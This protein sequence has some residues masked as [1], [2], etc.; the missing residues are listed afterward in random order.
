MNLWDLPI[1]RLVHEWNRIDEGFT[2]HAAIRWLC[3]NDR[4]YLLVRACRRDDALHPWLLARCREV[5]RNPDGYLDLWAREHYKST[6]ITFAGSIQEILK[7]PEITIAIFSHTRPIARKFWTQIKQEFESNIVLKTIFPDV[8]YQDPQKEAPRW[9]E[10]KGIVVKRKQNIRESTLES[11]GLVD[12]QPTGAH[13]KLM[14]YDDVMTQES[15]STPE[16][17]AKTTAAWELSDNLGM[18]GGRKW[19]IGTRYSFADTYGA[20][21]TRGSVAARVY[22]ATKDGE[23]D[24]E[25]VFFTPEVWEQKKRDQGEQVIACQMLQNPIAGQQAMF[26]AEWLQ[27]Y[28]V[29]PETVNVYIMCDPARSMKKDSAKTA[30]AVVAVDA[31]RNK[32]LVDGMNHRM[33]L[34]ERWESLRSLWRKWNDMPGVQTVAVGYE[35]Y[36]AQADLEY[37]QE[38]MDVEGFAFPI[39]EL[40]WPR[41]G[42]GSKEDRVQRLVPDFRNSRFYLPYDT[43]EKRYTSQQKRAILEGSPYRVARP[44]RRKDN[45]GNLYD[46]RRQ[47]VEQVHFFPFGSQKDLI[48]AVSRIYDMD[49]QAPVTL[50]EFDLEPEVTVD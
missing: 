35:R 15:V 37:F 23:P 6:I 32:Y 10:E 34:K 7:D 36:G 16:Q 21:L 14:I 28:E 42:L 2:N 33:D 24:G 9:S 26:R 46:L 38:R 1:D 30:M 47:F 41:E 19:H 11:W 45:D 18:A 17:I 3:L 22:P 12:G 43:D 50:G 5:E 13:F 20:I 49:V 27:T 44:I 40:E 4:Y 48:D 39:M 8:L 25:P 31:G 29:R